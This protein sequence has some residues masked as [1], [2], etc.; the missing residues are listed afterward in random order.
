MA[1]AD[2]AE[3]LVRSYVSQSHTE[4]LTIETDSQIKFKFIQSGSLHESRYTYIFSD[5]IWSCVV[6]HLKKLIGVYAELVMFSHGP[7]C[8][9]YNVQCTVRCKKGD[10]PTQ[11]KL[12]GKKVNKVRC[13]K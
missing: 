9:L 4:L 6:S 12:G 1:G 5:V 7:I 3:L 8:T 2:T 11:E 13:K 10:Q